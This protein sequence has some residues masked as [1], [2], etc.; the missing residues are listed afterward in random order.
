MGVF[1]ADEEV[2]SEGAKFY[3]RDTPPA[4]DFAVIGEPTSNA[5]F[6]AH[7]G[8][9]RPRVRVK[10]VTAHSGTPELGVNA[11]YQSARLLGLIEEAHH[12]QVRC[13]CH[14]LVGNASLT[15][16][17]IHGGHVDNV[18][19]DSCELLLDRRMVPGKTKRL[20]KPNC[21]SCSTTRTRRQTMEAEIIA[22]SHHRRRDAN[23]QQRSHCRAKP[24]RLPP[25]RTER[26]RPVWFS[27]RLRL[28]HFCSLGA[29]GVVIGPGSLAV[30]HKPDEFV[31]VDEFIAAAD[32]YLDI[33][34]AM[35]PPASG[36]ESAALSGDLHY[37][38]VTLHTAASGPVT[39]L[40]TLWLRT[41][42]RGVT[43]IGEVRLNIRYLH[44]YRE[45][46]VL[47]N[48]L[49]RLNGWDWRQQPAAQLAALHEEGRTLL[50]P[51]RMAL[52]MALH[53]LMAR[54]NGVN[55]AARLGAPAGLP[56]WHTNQTL[57]WGS[58]AE[59]LAQAQRYVDRGFTQLKLRTG[60][61][62]F[63]TDWPACKS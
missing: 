29:K 23:R 21:N 54:Q 18:V 27:G 24:C 28:V 12:L 61:A 41:E 20:L 53:D 34:L 39:A 47:N 17:R 48:L 63:A 3:V 32:I 42:D 19:P 16:T 46:Q 56:A 7:K 31:P 5:T 9:L 55:V 4:I 2:A 10:G 38:G 43:G 11:I 44:G 50:P 33:A 62:D 1:T 40:D 13:R 60:I 6:S 25:S 37:A 36:Y 15:V 52:D 57:F 22:G 35:L 58:E 49:Q 14:D 51:S 8:S 30:A 45:E 59:M 26:T